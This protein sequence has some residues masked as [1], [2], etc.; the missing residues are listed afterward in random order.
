MEITVDKAQ[1]KY[2]MRSVVLSEEE[3]TS[4]SS[5]EVSDMEGLKSTLQI[6]EIR[7]I[8]SANVSL[9]IVVVLFQ[10]MIIPIYFQY[11]CRAENEH[12]WDELTHILEVVGKWVSIIIISS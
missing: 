12:G 5:T 3:V 1:S 2:K 7:G 4:K 8:D 10:L 6:S 11:T 9:F